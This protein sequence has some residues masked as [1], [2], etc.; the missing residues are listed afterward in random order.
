L[1][2]TEWQGPIL[3]LGDTDTGKSTL[4][5]YLY[6]RFLQQD[7]SAAYLDID[8]GQNELGPP[9]TITLGLPGESD[10]VFPPRG[11][12]ALYFLGSNS[13][14]YHRLRLILGIRH[15]RRL[16]RHSGFRR[17]VVNTSGFIDGQQGAFTLKWA[18]VDLLRPCH[19]VA[20][21][22]QT[23]LEPMLA[24]LRRLPG[25]R[26]HTV[27]VATA[28]QRRSPEKRRQLRADKYRT[29]FQNAQRVSIS[30]QRRAVFPRLD[31]TPGQLCALEDNNGLALALAVVDEA[32]HDDRV[33]WV[34]T[35]WLQEERVAVIRLGTLCLNLDTFNDEPL[36]GDD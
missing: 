25:V 15:L 34:H 2:V 18:Q 36:Y 26:V 19:I 32:R 17:L 9:T 8:P 22:R 1:P 30:Y 23:E 14:R 6:G 28:V 21:Q 29:H 3:V 10:Q 11:S 16:A 13:P 20:I 4:A 24:P 12:K 33:L 35:P 31:F 5:R 27:P 7:P